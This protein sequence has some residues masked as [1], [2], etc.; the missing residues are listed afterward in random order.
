ME[1]PSGPLRVRAFGSPWASTSAAAG[2][3]VA[4]V[5]ASSVPLQRPEARSLTEARAGLCAC[6]T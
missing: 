4:T 5:G 6:L 2:H 1:A 3:P